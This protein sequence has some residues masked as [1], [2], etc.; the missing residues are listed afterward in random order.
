MRRRGTNVSCKRPIGTAIMMNGTTHRSRIPPSSPP[1]VDEIPL[2]T[3]CGAH[4]RLPISAAQ[5]RPGSNESISGFNLLF[6]TLSIIYT[7]IEFL[8]SCA[9]SQN[10]WPVFCCARQ[11][12]NCI[13]T[14]RELISAC[15]RARALQLN[16]I[17]SYLELPCQG[18]SLNQ[19]DNEWHGNGQR[20]A[21]WLHTSPPCECQTRTSAT[22]QLPGKDTHTQPFP[23]T[24]HRLFR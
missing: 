12:G 8:D 10:N 22:Q 9:R 23:S 19:S 3:R 13:I 15:G 20:S 1:P 4:G 5:W 2:A 7:P 17:E 18:L 14:G 24:F 16:P 21:R 11:S 6:S